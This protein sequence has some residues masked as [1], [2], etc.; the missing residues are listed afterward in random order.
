MWYV[1][2]G[3]GLTIPSGVNVAVG[4]VVSRGT[5]N[6]ISSNLRVLTGLRPPSVTLSLGC[7]ITCGSVAANISA[8]PLSGLPHISVPLCGCCGVWCGTG[9]QISLNLRVLIGLRPPS[10]TLSLGCWITCGSVA[11][12]ISAL[13]LSGLPHISVPLCGCCGVWCGTGNQISLNLQVLIGLRPPSVTLSLGCCVTCGSVA[14]NIGGLSL[15]RLPHISV[16]L[17]GCCGMWYSVL[18][19]VLVCRKKQFP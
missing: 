2:G 19:C 8:L 7:W 5:G 18:L 15:S 6:Q 14:A 12:N 13:P 9:N 3:G 17:C 1:G 16:P 11:A 10:V 4:D